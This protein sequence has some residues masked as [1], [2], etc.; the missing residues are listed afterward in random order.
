MCE[1]VMNP[2]Q[3]ANM[4]LFLAYCGPVSWVAQMI[5]CHHP[6]H[7]MFTVI[8]MW[9]FLLSFVPDIA[10]WAL[11]FP[12]CVCYRCIHRI[13]LSSS[14]QIIRSYL[15]LT[16]SSICNC[17]CLIV[18]VGLSRAV[19][20]SCKQCNSYIFGYFLSPKNIFCYLPLSP[21]HACV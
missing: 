15:M 10:Y 20:F 17:N 11:T 7:S 13:A 8:S 5:S 14:H 1:V 19:I 21:V 18:F 16:I 2:L 6:S 9:L 4:Q 3:T 12:I